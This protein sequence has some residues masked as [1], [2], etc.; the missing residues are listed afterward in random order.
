MRKFFLLVAG[1][2]MM[3]LPIRP[4]S[5]QGSE[6]E[7][8]GLVDVGFTHNFND[9]RR[10]TA[11]AQDNVGRFADRNEDTFQVT[12]AQ[13]AVSKEAEPVGFMLKLD[14]FETAKVIDAV[15]NGAAGGDD[16]AIQNAYIMWKVEVGS[17]LMVNA[18]KMGG[19]LGAEPIEA[20]GR[21]AISRGIVSNQTPLTNMGLRLEYPL[22]DNL[23]VTMGVNNGADDDVDPGHGKTYEAK[24]SFSPTEAWNASL[25]INYGEDGD[26]ADSD[27]SPEGNRVFRLDVITSYAFTEDLSAWAEFMYFNFEDARVEGANESDSD[28]WAFAI[29]ARYKFSDKYGVSARYEYLGIEKAGVIN[30]A[31][32]D[33]N[34]WEFTLTGHVWITED[35]EFRI[36][37]RH[38]N[39]NQRIFADDGAAGTPQATDDAQDTLGVALLYIF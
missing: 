2:S 32:T 19:L 16:I 27:N 7:I 21:Y 28:L 34:F 17:G 29:A 6:V 9:P 1:L 12:L 33:L 31:S 14:F 5:A 20:T 38:D 10:V 30:A 3:V 26:S 11:T 25:A 35:L 4:V 22:L 13:L 24:I 39:S 36:E 37:Y 23:S 8:S 18:G 15:N